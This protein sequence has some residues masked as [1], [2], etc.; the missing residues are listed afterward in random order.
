MLRAFGAESKSYATRFDDE[1]FSDSSIASDGLPGYLTKDERKA[2]AARVES[3][4]D[5]LSLE[6]YNRCGFLTHTPTYER[7]ILGKHSLK[8][9]EYVRRTD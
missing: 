4:D 1:D 3:R 5:V 6:T 8:D 2:A 7:L 9:D